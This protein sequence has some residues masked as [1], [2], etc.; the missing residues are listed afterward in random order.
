MLEVLNFVEVRRPVQRA[1]PHPAATLQRRGVAEPFTAIG[2]VPH[3]S[4]VRAVDVATRTAQVAL[5]R[6]SWI[7]SIVEDL[8]AA[9]DLGRETLSLGCCDRC[10][11]VARGV[12]AVEDRGD[13][14]HRYGA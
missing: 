6:H 1:V 7:R 5:E 13:V 14:D 2:E 12:A 10:D 8:L 9:Q 3:T 4:V 11:Y